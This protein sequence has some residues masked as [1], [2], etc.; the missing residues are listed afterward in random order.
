MQWKIKINTSG[1]K[2][3][4]I[5]SQ[6]KDYLSLKLYCLLGYPFQR[7][8]RPEE[9]LETIAGCS[10][11]SNIRLNVVMVS[12]HFMPMPFT[13]M[14]NEPVN[15]TNFRDKI[16]AYDFSKYQT[17]NVKVYWPWAL[18]SS[19]INAMEATVV[20][21]AKADDAELIKRILCS[22]KYKALQYRGKI[23][24]LN[25]AF[26]QYLGQYDDVIPYV[27]RTHP[28]DA[29]KRKYHQMVDELTKE[30]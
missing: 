4:E 20:H 8:F 22:S 3:N 28:L 26:G 21:R 16:K 30:V 7:D 24:I 5:Y 1:K 14:E 10:R 29:A 18:A 17:G 19:P 23:A 2:I 15:Q 13:P 27:K 25:K 11:N 12:P 9:T 6:S